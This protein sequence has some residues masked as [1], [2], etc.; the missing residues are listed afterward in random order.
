MK[1]KHLSDNEWTNDFWRDTLETDVLS[2]YIMGVIAAKVLS[3]FLEIWKTFNDY[4]L[5]GE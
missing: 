5:E 3:L 4:L 1:E 2:A